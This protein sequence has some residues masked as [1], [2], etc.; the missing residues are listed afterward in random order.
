MYTTDHGDFDGNSWEEFCQLCFKHKYEKEGYQ[1]LPAWRGDL[2]IEGFT[3]SGIAFQCYC[4]DENYNHDVLYEKQRDKITKDLNKLVL[5]ENDLKLYLETVKISKWIFV[6][7]QYQNKEL[8]RHCAQKA[9]EYRIKKLDILSFDFDILVHDLGFFTEQI[10]FILDA[11]I[12]KI[13]LNHNG[14]S[15][16]DINK[17]FESTIDLVEN[18]NRKNAHRIS[19]NAQNRDLKIEKL[20][21]ITVSNF[22]NGNTTITKLQQKFPDDYE[23]LVRTISQFEKKVEELCLTNSASSNDLYFSIENE[24]KQRIKETFPYLNGNTINRLT[25]QV[26]ADW[27]LRCPIDFE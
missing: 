11:K 22:L 18:A 4:P 19:I 5:N 16:E 23:K 9:K 12:K 20:T 15:D 1:E 3:K 26:L 2:G 7:P 13:D 17:W 10:P 27:I 14:E 24:L 25:E 21:K 8:I 6:T